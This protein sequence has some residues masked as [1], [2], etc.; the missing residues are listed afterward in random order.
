MSIILLGRWLSVSLSVLLTV[1][2]FG[3]LGSGLLWGT[4]YGAVGL[5]LSLAQFSLPERVRSHHRHSDN[6]ALLGTVTLFLALQVV[7]LGASVGSLS[8]SL[9]NLQQEASVVS[10]QRDLLLRQVDQELERVETWNRYDQPSK[11]SDTLVRIDALRD[12]LATLPV[13]QNSNAISLVDTLATMTGYSPQAVAGAVYVVLS[14]LLDACAVY[15]LLSGTGNTGNTPLPAVTHRA[16]ATVTLE[17]QPSLLPEPE[18]VPQYQAIL[19]GVCQLSV[20]A[21]MNHYRVGSRG[22]YAILNE[23]QGMGQVEKDETT[24]RYR[25]V[26]RV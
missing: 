9:G 19:D 20:R 6:G 7:S 3:S 22:A 1:A 25:L 21:I 26:T 24:N 5:V 17:E 8:A 14:V 12:E 23:L 18:E 16:T 11:A 2:L 15:F 4:V 13:V 10:Q